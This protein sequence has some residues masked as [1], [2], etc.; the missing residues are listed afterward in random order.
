MLDLSR[1]D[2]GKISMD[3]VDVEME[4]AIDFAYI[5]FRHEAEKKNIELAKN[6]AGNPHVR[7]D[8]ER[9]QQVLNNL[10][11]NEDALPSGYSYQFITRGADGTE[12]LDGIPFFY[13]L[14][15]FN[16]VFMLELGF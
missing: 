9:I 16:A 15:T 2:A 8:V 4:Y 5:S 11:S 10:L 13:P 6:I 1:L 14:A 7:G 12:N 3:F